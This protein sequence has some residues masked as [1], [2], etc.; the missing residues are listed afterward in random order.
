MHLGPGQGP[1][2]G[3]ALT[4]TGL[5]Q[6]SQWHPATL[7]DARAVHSFINQTVIDKGMYRNAGR[8]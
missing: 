4:E 6:V 8:D 7:L 3:Q 5:Y 1:G 2:L